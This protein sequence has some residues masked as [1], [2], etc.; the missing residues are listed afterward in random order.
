MLEDLLVPPRATMMRQ[1][2]EARVRR[3]GVRMQVKRPSLPMVMGGGGGFRGVGEVLGRW[4][5]SE[6]GNGYLTRVKA[7]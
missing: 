4:E 5:R 3:N 1:I 2:R 7:S 6:I